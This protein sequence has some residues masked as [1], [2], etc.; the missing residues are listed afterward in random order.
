M[1][2]ECTRICFFVYMFCPH[3][4][5]AAV[6]VVA[7][8]GVVAAAFFV[9]F[10]VVTLVSPLLWDAC[11]FLATLFR[12]KA[13]TTVDTNACVEFDVGNYSGGNTPHVPRPLMPSLVIGYFWL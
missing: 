13:I 9:V 6:V 7:A 5:G 1:R 8:F 4:F 12:W 10:V 3:R 11:V 2:S